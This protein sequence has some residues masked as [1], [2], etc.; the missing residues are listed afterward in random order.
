[1]DVHPPKNGMYRYWP[2]PIWL[3][4]YNLKTEAQSSV[5]NPFSIH[6]WNHVTDERGLET[7]APP[8]FLFRR[9]TSELRIRIDHVMPAICK[10]KDQR[11]ICRGPGTSSLV[12]NQEEQPLG[13][14]CWL[15]VCARMC[16]PSILL[17]YHI[18]VFSWKPQ[19]SLWLRAILLE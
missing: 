7:S 5:E 9:E 4:I 3:H 8:R 12:A 2:I 1:M 16:C 11:R 6:E 14:G 10:W 15:R 19:K 18:F 17:V 13:Y